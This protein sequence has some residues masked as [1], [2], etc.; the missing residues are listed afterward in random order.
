MTP[1]PSF[2]KSK[3]PVRHAAPPFSTTLSRFGNGFLMS[4]RGERR[5]AWVK[6]ASVAGSVRPGDDDMRGLR[7]V[8]LLCEGDLSPKP[9]AANRVLLWQNHVGTEISNGFLPCA[10]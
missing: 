8:D 1:M 7:L 5:K 2:L 6:G 9:G 10:E 4:G 3:I